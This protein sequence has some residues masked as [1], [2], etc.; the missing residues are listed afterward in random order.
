M[1]G[2]VDE[3]DRMLLAL[4]IIPITN[5]IGANYFYV[6]NLEL[7]FIK[8]VLSL[9]FMWVVYTLYGEQHGFGI[10]GPI[11]VGSLFLIGLIIWW[12]GDIYRLCIK[13]K[14]KK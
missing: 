12:L 7:G 1:S 14:I 11:F 6:G 9:L 2:K 8:L 4:T 10:I 13:N 3:K 5:F